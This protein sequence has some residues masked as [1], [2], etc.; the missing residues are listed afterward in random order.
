MIE[1][2]TRNIG[3]K[4]LNKSDMTRSMNCMSNDM[5]VMNQC[6]AQPE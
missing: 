6:V 2:T 1:E 3:T 5:A 4:I